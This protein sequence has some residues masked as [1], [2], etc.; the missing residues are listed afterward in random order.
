MVA[1]YLVFL[2]M[3]AVSG[4]TDGVLSEVIYILAFA[5]PIAAGLLL[6]K[7]ADEAESGEGSGSACRADV[8]IRLG[9]GKRELSLFLPAVFPTLLGIVA[10]SYVTSVIL[11]F[12]G[13]ADGSV[14]EGTMPIAVINYALLPAV[15][16]E[17]L[18]RHLPIRLLAPHSPRG[19]VVMSAV[20]FSLVHTDLFRI[21][22]AFLAGLTFIVI[23]MLTGSILPSL[24][25][26]FINNLMSV[27]FAFYPAGET[28]FLIYIALLVI[29][30]AISAVFIYR[31]RGE[32]GLRMAAVLK[33]G[34][35]AECFDPAPLALIIPTLLL[36]IL[37]LFAK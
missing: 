37:N 36:A 24:I 3:L 9:L 1:C 23:D 12:F 26:H 19:A 21:P 2:V 7:R 4:M 11:G 13:F 18:F 34:D 25:I 30:T 27:I 20:F 14:I 8:G 6:S 35:I 32:Y 15:L 31:M 22:Y 17:L 29:M 16:E 5:I 10:L 33:K 28:A